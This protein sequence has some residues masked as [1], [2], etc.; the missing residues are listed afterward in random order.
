MDI[1]ELSVILV[2]M[3]ME[4]LM[5]ITVGNVHQQSIMYGQDLNL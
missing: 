5:K 4:K 1:Q 3:I 2:Q